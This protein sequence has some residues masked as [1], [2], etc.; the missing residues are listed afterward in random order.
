MNKKN[1]AEERNTGDDDGEELL[2]GASSSEQR[3]KFSLIPVCKRVEEEKKEPFFSCDY[4]RRVY[5]MYL[6]KRYDAPIQ[7]LS[8]RYVYYGQ[9]MKSG[10]DGGARA[11]NDCAK[12]RRKKCTIQNECSNYLYTDCFLHAIRTVRCLTF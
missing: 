8:R 5:K 9:N 4:A 2:A 6:H 11:R 12:V 3:C 1:T 10:N 7:R